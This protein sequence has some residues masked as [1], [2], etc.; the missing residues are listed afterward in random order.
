MI[1]I[2]INKDWIPFIV[3]AVLAMVLLGQ[4]SRV[5]T[6]KGNIESLE[7][8]VANAESNILASKD[9]VDMFINA[10]NFLEAEIKT[11]TYTNEQLTLNNNEIAK[12]YT[13]A[14]SLNKKLEGVKVLLTAQL[15]TKDTIFL[16][17]NIGS[18]NTFTFK[19]SSDFGDNNTRVIKLDAKISNDSTVIGNFTIAQTMTLLAAF[20]KDSDGIN[21]MRISTKY[22]FD[23]INIQGIE[24]IN[25]ELN[26]YRKK[27][28]WNI[29]FGLGYGIYQSGS[30]LRIA[31]FV[32][33]TLG[34]SPKWLQF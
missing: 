17:S 21:R 12:K 26:I 4:C 16:N 25:N 32:G 28:R 10:N 19:D 22:P 13:D 14:L 1:N 7:M 11:F 20:E 27:S 34:Y 5:S 2:N 24:L 33:T 6:L 31:P 15:Q 9:T 3:I 18:D 30:I 8:D 23:N 29:N